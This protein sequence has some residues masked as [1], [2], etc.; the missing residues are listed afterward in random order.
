M[1]NDVD[2]KDVVQRVEGITLGQ[3]YKVCSSYATLIA[4][5]IALLTFTVK[6]YAEDFV[7]QTVIDK[8]FATKKS[9]DSIDTRTK[10]LEEQLGALQKQQDELKRTLGTTA[11]DTSRIRTLQEEQNTNIETILRALTSPN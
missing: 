6:P 11:S 7:V 4:A 2:V 8:Q 5:A 1:T 10:D 9:L 3:L